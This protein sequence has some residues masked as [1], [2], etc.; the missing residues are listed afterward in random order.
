MLP[1]QIDMIQDQIDYQYA[2]WVEAEIIK[3]EME[4]ERRQKIAEVA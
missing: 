1:D 3:A 2:S 4:A